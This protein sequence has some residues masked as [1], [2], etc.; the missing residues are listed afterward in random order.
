[1]N[2]LN[3]IADSLTPEQIITLVTELGADRYVETDGYV[4]FPTICH[5]VDPSDAQ[6]KLYYYKKNKRFHCYTECG[7]TFNIFT[8]FKRR[9]DLLQIEYNFYTDIVLKVKSLSPIQNVTKGFQNKYVSKMTKYDKQE[10]D[11]DIPH[12]NPG[13]LDVYSF[14][15]TPEWLNDGISVESMREYNIKF[16]IDENKIII[17][18][19]NEEGYLI[20]I[21]GRALNPE[22]LAKGKYMPVYIEG[23]LKA[24]PLGY[25]LYGLN[26]VRGNI[27][28]KQI[29]IIGEGE[30]FALQYNTMFGHSENIAVAACGSNISN[31][32]IDLLLKAG[33][34]KILVAFDKEGETWDERQTRYKKLFNLCERF[35]YKCQMGF[36]FD[37]KNL[38]R[39]KESPTDRG[40]ETFLEL[41]K[42]A[43]WL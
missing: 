34:K 25:N 18:H 20:G 31:Y 35:S 10:V 29:A 7:D 16:S 12:L 37:S 17:P 26:Y 39:L 11:V 15:P 1:M 27:K 32:Q 4:L 9:Y 41:Y 22:D 33:V 28:R 43:I 40:K 23:K 30:K 14:F 38:L 21:R 2:N 36:I 19:Y 42:G 8:L 3:Q 24:H 6:M 5:N 13:I